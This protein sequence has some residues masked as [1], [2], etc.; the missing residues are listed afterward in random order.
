MIVIKIIVKRKKMNEVQDFVKNFANSEGQHKEINNF[1]SGKIELI[2]NN[3]EANLK[4]IKNLDPAK[5][6]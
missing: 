2:A 4:I 1:F 3:P 5:H 6:T